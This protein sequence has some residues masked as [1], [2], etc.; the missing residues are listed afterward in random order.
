MFVIQAAGDLYK[1]NKKKHRIQATII[2]SK[3]EKIQKGNTIH[4]E[5]TRHYNQMQKKIQKF[6][7]RIQGITTKCKNTNNNMI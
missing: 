6:I 2:Y 7:V 3:I 4:C 1:K 5:N